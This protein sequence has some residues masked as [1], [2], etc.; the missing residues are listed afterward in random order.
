MKNVSPPLRLSIEEAPKL[1]LKV[2]TALKVCI[3]SEEEYFAGHHCCDLNSRQEECLVAVLKRL[4][5]YWV[6]YYEIS[7]GFPRYLLSQ[8]QLMRA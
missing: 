7:L 8:I 3:L 4:S 5:E 2:T 1:E 6:D